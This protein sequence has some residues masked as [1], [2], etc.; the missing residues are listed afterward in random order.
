ML[1]KELMKKI[2]KI[3]IK[4]LDYL[5]EEIIET[6]A[7]VEPEQMQQSDYENFLF[8]ME[9]LRVTQG[10]NTGT[11]LGSKAMDFGGKD[12]GRDEL[13]AP[14]TMRVVRI[15]ENRNGEI[16]FESTRPVRFADGSLDYA[17]LLCLHDDSTTFEVGDIIQQGD[18][19]YSEGG[20]G[21]G[22]PH[23]FN[24]HV[25]IEAGKGKWEN[26]KHFL[27]P[28]TRDKYTIEN[29]SSLYDLF[30]LPRDTIE[31]DGGGYSWKYEK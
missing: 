24:N 10:E 23:K 25:H 30:F 7:P 17:R 12:T 27:V 20:M 9:Y 11:H 4:I 1:D 31:Y 6:G 2:L 18:Y 19:F 3:I 8:P 13:Y 29:P 28:G 21:G 14:C 16:Y 22:D 26:A 5:F 15:R